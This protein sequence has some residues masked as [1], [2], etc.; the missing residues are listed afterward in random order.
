MER[1][2]EK[3]KRYELATKQQATASFARI[4][5][6]ALTIRQDAQLLSDIA[7]TSVMQGKSIAIKDERNE[8]EPVFTVRFRKMK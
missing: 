3:K 5:E 2:R 4:D 8:Y 7:L 1:L 6:L